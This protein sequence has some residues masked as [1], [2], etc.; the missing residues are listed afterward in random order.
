MQELSFQLS[1]IRLSA[2]AWGEPEQPRVV[3][4]HGWLDNGASFAPLAE[5]LEGYQLIALDWPGHGHSDHRPIGASYH[6]VDYVYDLYCLIE[7]QQ[8][9]PVH[10]IGHS[11]GAIVASMFAG[12]FPELVD[13]LVLIEAL[14]PITA[15]PNQSRSNLRKAA[16][17]QYQLT[18]K[19]KPVHGDL[20]SAIKARQAASDFSYEIAKILVSRG[21]D[22]VEGGYTWRSDIRLRSHSPWRMTQAQAHNIV[23]GISAPTLLFKG[24]RGLPMVEDAITNR[25]AWLADL[26]VEVLAG[27]H[28]LHMETPQLVAQK[29]HKHFSLIK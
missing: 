22:Q 15:E 4:L 23:S 29:I 18:H 26:T 7:E 14:G 28:H 5:H 16:K 20:E 17:S 27:G 1:H 3:A 11:L 10:I 2:L 19:Q 8:W 12:A 21:V 13:R 24:T 9:G 25:A 6:L